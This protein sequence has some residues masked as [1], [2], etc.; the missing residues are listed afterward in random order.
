MGDVY[1][2]FS[3]NISGEGICFQVLE[4]MPEK[5]H[6]NLIINI[7]KKKSILVKGEVAWVSEAK[8]DSIASERIFQIGVKFL[9]V[10][11]KDKNLLNEFL[12][13]I[14]EDDS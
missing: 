4:I 3:Q 7:P 5:S 1:R 12:C 10:N 2:A 9:K 11:T 8:R 6:V 14:V 13:K